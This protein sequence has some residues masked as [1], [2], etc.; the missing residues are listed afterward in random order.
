MRLF[1]FQGQAAALSVFGASSVYRNE[2]DRWGPEQA[3]TEVSTTNDHYWHSTAGDRNP[4]ITFKL[5]KEHEIMSVEV[6]DRQDCCHNRFINVEVRVGTTPSF[7][8]AATCGI[9]SFAGE[10]K[11][12]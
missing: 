2:V 11:Y 6:V 10:T 9:Q 5:Q 3:L 4:T 1:L 7:K 8:E 12:K